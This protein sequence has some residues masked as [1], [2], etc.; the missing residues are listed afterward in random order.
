[1]STADPGRQG[2]S[3]EPRSGGMPKPSSPVVA[4]VI[5]AVAGLLG[6]LILRD[7]TQDDSGD[8]GGGSSQ[9]T[10]VPVASS[11]SVGA[12]TS[13]TQPLRDGAVVLV[14]N[15][16]GQEGVA[17]QLTTALDNRGYT[18]AKPTNC[19][20][21]AEEVTVI[22]VKAGDAVAAQVARTLA[23][24]MGVTAEIEA[25]PADPGISG[26]LGSATILV[27]L[28]PDKA[29]QPLRV[30]GAASVPATTA[31]ATTTADATDATDAT[32]ASD[33]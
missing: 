22:M 11:T 4:I 20:G 13:T 16:S 23:S 10:T 18:T 27:L 26:E 12:T 33:G 1:M 19:S 14:A 25:M 24:E 28:A 30:I 7:V 32:D 15:C 2:R 8:S 29:G 3:G 6:L 31:T 17:G 9:R 21:G 5:A